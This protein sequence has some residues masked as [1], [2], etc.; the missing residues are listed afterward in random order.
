MPKCE[1]DAVLQ[2]QVHSFVRE[3]GLTVN[4]AA[5]LLAVNRTTFWRFH[6]TGEA[7]SSTRTRIRDALENRNKQTAVGASDDAVRPNG[8]EHQARLMLPGVPADRELK[9]IRRACEGILALLN[10]YE[11]Q[12]A[13]TRKI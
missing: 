12:Q 10:A 9:Q 5:T 6:E 11:A 3:S 8:H 13:L 4:G 2:H 7:L 1:V